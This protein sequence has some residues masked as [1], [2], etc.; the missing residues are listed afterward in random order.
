MTSV[1]VV[2]A[3]LSGLATAWYLADAGL[4]VQIVD[5]ASLPGG[6]ISTRRVP[7]GL[8]ETAANAFVTSERVER[9]FRAA[10]VTPLS[11]APAAR[12]RYVFRSGR[13]RRWPMTAMET[14]LAAARMSAATV[15]GRRAPRAAESVGAWGER[16]FGRAAVDRLLSPALQG[17]YGAAADE[18]SARAVFGSPRVRAPLV[19]PAGGMGEL[20]ERLASALERRGV[21]FVWNR[22]VVSLPAGEPAV[23]A[24]PAAAAAPLLAPH[25]PR[26]AAAVSRIRMASIATVTAFFPPHPEDLRGFGVLFP[27][28]EGVQALGVLFNSDI[29]AGRSSLRSETWIYRAAP[30]GTPETADDFR[31]Q[32]A[33]D[34]VVLTGRASSPIAVYPTL[35]PAALPIYDAAVIDAAAALDDLPPWLGVCGNYLGRLGVAKLLDVAAETAAR[36]SGNC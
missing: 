21:R 11:P 34:R 25:A 1:R 29:F 31:P 24:V 36:L 23:L 10:G 35:W 7:E 3:G 17:I 27:R 9:L 4:S 16:V 15:L 30:A 14:A 28:G 6:L 33:A 20:V 26:L 12:R 18:L 13:P 19:A 8:V 22:P 32:L 5:R 2:G